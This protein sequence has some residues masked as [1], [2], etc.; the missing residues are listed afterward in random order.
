[1]RSGT[2][3]ADRASNTGETKMLF[4]DTYASDTH[5]LTGDDTVLDDGNIDLMGGAS[6]PIGDIDLTGA[7]SKPTGGVDNYSLSEDAMSWSWGVTQQGAKLGAGVEIEA[8]L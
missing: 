3:A 8:E 4:D 7:G 1:M 5:W 2:S 6:K